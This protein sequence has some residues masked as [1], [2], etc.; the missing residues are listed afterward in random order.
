MA[1]K[2]V[3]QW[4]TTGGTVCTSLETAQELETIELIMD[5]IDGC[6]TWRDES[7][8]HDEFLDFLKTSADAVAFVEAINKVF[9]RNPH[10]GFKAAPNQE[11]S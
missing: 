9:A 4:V 5:T 11:V 3:T 1:I 10:N 8:E 2:E 6:I 7:F